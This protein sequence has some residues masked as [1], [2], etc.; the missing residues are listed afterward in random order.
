MNH[1]DRYGAENERPQKIG[2]GTQ[3]DK[4]MEQLLEIEEQQKRLAERREQLVAKAQGHLESLYEMVK[5]R[6]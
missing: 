4:V 2:H 6:G 1:D 3:L 5:S